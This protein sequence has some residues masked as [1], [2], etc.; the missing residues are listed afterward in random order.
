MR[1]F[2]SQVVASS[3]PN[4]NAVLGYKLAVFLLSIAVFALA[5]VAWTFFDKSRKLQ[6][7]VT[8]L[9]A[10]QV[11]L[12]VPE[13]QA[14][15]IA[16]WMQQHPQQTASL[17]DAVKPVAEGTMT[18]QQALRAEQ[19]QP[20]NNRLQSGEASSLKPKTNKQQGDATPI[21]Q[22]AKPKASNI[23]GMTVVPTEH[24][25]VIITTRDVSEN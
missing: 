6:R 2:V 25:G 15:T 14:A 1:L 8:N 3:E 16:S 21:Q 17:L 12:M 23:D 22:D 24:G 11:M 20:L 5:T 19:Q 7:Q 18:Q 10:S 4:N 13:E 9:Q